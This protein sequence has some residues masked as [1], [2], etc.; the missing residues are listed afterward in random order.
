[1]LK[2]G[3]RFDRYEIVSVL[4]SGGMGVVYRARHVILGCDVALKALL[5]NFAMQPRVRERFVRE[6][7]VQ[8][9]LKHPGIV[10]V[11]DVIT[12]GSELVLVMPL[13]EGPSL[14]W[15]LEHE[16]P[17]AWPLGEALRLLE[18]VADAIACAHR[19]GVV[20]RDIKPANVLLDRESTDIW[21][22]AARIVDFGIARV[23]GAASGLT[24]T[25][26]RLGTLVYM[27]P[28]QFRGQRAID[29][30][31]DVY[32]LGTLAWRLLAGRLPADPNDLEQV[33]GLYAGTR[34]AQ[35]LDALD[36]RVSAGV[37]DVVESALAVDPARRPADA[38]CF[39]AALKAA[40]SELGQGAS[41]EEAGAS[42]SL[43]GAE[44][45]GEA[46]AHTPPSPAAYRADGGRVCGANA[47]ADP[48]RARP[49]EDASAVGRAPGGG[50]EPANDD[51]PAA[52]E[53]R[54]IFPVVD[55]DD[56]AVR[57]SPTRAS[58]GR[59]CLRWTLVLGA[60]P[61]ALLVGALA[62]GAAGIIVGS[63]WLAILVALFLTVG[64]R[65]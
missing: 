9:A 48:H 58:S 6:A 4:G 41:A 24:H 8:A 33:L 3:D 42:R 12:T 18:E 1:M 20:H 52:V 31:A 54:W 56:S 34:K 15:V 61:S 59:G 17:G 51:P 40:R 64:E 49:L 21:P 39:L 47:A 14:Q 13:V 37:A 38:G 62:G 35:R 57:S 26:A 36:A 46:A 55:G 65:D 11:T 7:Q 2:E 60:L 16:R 25:G 23:A 30:R 22:G 32:A 44:L 53:I 5:P 29:A 19:S 27:A 63:I 50:E 10:P 45:A 28:E 43:G